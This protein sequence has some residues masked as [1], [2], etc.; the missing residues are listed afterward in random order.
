MTRAG[1]PTVKDT[2]NQTARNP[3][4][5]LGRGEELGPGEKL[6]PGTEHEARGGRGP[7][8]ETA[9][10]RRQRRLQRELALRVLI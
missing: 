3:S 1:E 6:G 9:E 4:E 8:G 7:G 5:E 10:Q 2:G